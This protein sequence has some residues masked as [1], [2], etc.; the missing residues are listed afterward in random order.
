MSLDRALQAW[1]AAICSSALP[2][3][4]MPPANLGYRFYQTP[5]YDRLQ[6]WEVR[7]LV[8]PA[9][10]IARL[11]ISMERLPQ[12]LN[13]KDDGILYAMAMLY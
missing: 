11:I 3:Q 7:I 6:I 5:S 10:E 1:A 13:A 12:L 4:I 8:A 9:D 2:L